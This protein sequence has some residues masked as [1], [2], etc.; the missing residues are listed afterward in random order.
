MLWNAVIFGPGKSLPITLTKYILSFPLFAIK[1]PVINYEWL[2]LLYSG[3]AF[4]RWN[5]QISLDV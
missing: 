1:V 5:L 4:R 3:Y 2:I